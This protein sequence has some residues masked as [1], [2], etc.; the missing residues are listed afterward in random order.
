MTAQRRR[1]GPQKPRTPRLDGPLKPGINVVNDGPAENV[2][3]PGGLPAPE[4][5]VSGGIVPQS[6]PTHEPIRIEIRSDASSATAAAAKAHE[7]MSAFPSPI[8]FVRFR[9]GWG[10][11]DTCPA[12]VFDGEYVAAL[13]PPLA[14]PLAGCRFVFRAPPGGWSYAEAHPGSGI[15]EY[16]EA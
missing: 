9:F 7:Q 1:R 11:Q 10:Y 5:I 8:R 15:G 16:Q 4:P 3:E 2:P 12:I 6:E 13:I 14:H